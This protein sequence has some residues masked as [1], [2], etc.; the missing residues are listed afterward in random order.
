LSTARASE[1]A[2]GA[3]SIAGAVAGAVSALGFTWLHEVL[4]SDIWWMWVPMLVAGAV[5]GL[6]LGLAFAVIA[7]HATIRTWVLYNA[8]IVGLFALFGVASLIA[9]EPVTTIDVLLTLDGPP[10]FLFAQ[11]VPLTIGFV[12]VS[13]VAIAVAFGHRWWHGLVVLVAMI[14]L[15]LFLGLNVSALGLVEL[16]RSDLYLVGIL[17]GLIAALAAVYAAAFLALRWGY[18]TAGQRQVSGAA[19]SGEGRTDRSPSP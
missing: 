1:S 12:I 18:F 13:S 3:A 16:H 10:D 6:L 11:T 5:C 4:I 7:R 19:V 9:Y 8:A 17:F 2:S 15:T 14:P